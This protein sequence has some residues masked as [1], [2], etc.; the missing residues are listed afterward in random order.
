ML[1]SLWG[2]PNFG[3]KISKTYPANGCRVAGFAFPGM[4][5]F[6]VL[7]ANKQRVAFCPGVG[8]M[9]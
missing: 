8:A 2:A 5:V 1:P 7:V 4:L 6:E 9:C 3:E